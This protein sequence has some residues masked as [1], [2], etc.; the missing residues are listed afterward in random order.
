MTD[1]NRLGEE[2]SN[3]W[4]IYKKKLNWMN[5]KQIDELEKSVY[6]WAI[7][8]ADDNDI[9]KN[10]E[11]E[12]FKNIYLRKAVAIAVNLDPSAYIKN[13]HLCKELRSNEIKTKEIPF[14]KP[15]QMFPGNWDEILRQKEK[16]EKTIFEEKPEAMTD[17]FRCGKCKKR[18]CLY[19]EV[20]TRSCDEPMTIFVK[21]ISCGNNWSM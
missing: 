10:W 13:D 1:F 18:E 21:C 15:E 12:R 3:V 7:Q 6:N 8:F 5:D 4:G 20:Q 19:R 2:R 16:K 11:N 14:L 17:Q 9:T